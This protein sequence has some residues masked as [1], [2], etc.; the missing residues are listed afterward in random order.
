MI[1]LLAA[2]AL[3]A[4]PAMARADRVAE[5]LASAEVE[6]AGMDAGGLSVEPGAV[7]PADLDGDGLEDD[8]V[9]DFAAVFC[10][11]NLSHWHGTGGAPIHFVI[12]GARS[13]SWWAHHWSLTEFDGMRV[14]LLSRHGSY[15]DSYGAA[16]CVQALVAGGTEFL[17]PVDGRP[18]EG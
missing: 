13:R 4:M 12:D 16:P 17:T 8:A 10:D 2:A 6:C 3:L 9:V 14:I 15:C 7:T 1:R 11:Y 5:I 18:E